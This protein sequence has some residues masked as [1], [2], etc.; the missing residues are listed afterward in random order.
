M[1]GEQGMFEAV[2]FRLFN[3]AGMEASR[4]HWVHFRIIDEAEESPRDQ[5]RGDF[6]GLY[7][8]VENVD[9]HFLKEHDLPAGNLYKIEGRAK[10]AFNGD[11]AITNQ[12]DV[13]EFLHSSARRQQASW[14]LSNVDLAHYYDYRSIIEC[15]HHYDVSGGKNYFYY[16]N[17]QSHKWMVIPWDIDLTWGDQM[18]GGGAEPFY[19]AGVLSNPQFKREYQERLAEIRDLLFNPEQTG[20]LI[21]EH[22]AMISDPSGSPSLVDADRAKWDYNPIEESSRVVPMKAGVGKFYFANPNNTFRAMV[23]YMKSYVT[24]RDKWIDS[25]LL[26]DYQPPAAPKIAQPRALDFSGPN[27]TLRLE[28]KPDSAVQSCRWRLAEVTDPRSASFNPRQPWKYEIQSLWDQEIKDPQEAA[29]IPTKLLVPAHIYR[30]R[31][32]WQE[33]DG[34]WSRWSAPLQFTV[35]SQ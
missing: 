31:A 35:P 28:S 4:T 24:K 13:N 12:R 10:T 27:L 6:W 7:L 25:R 32:R 30:V 9:E 21:D 3:L 29:A 2:G 8:A 15:I 20:R 26:A 23:D 18:F 1:R 19:R 14:W 34:A 11:P 22:A 17:P 5:Y 33:A 16:L